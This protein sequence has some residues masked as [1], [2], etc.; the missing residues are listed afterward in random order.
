[1]P[2]E[3]LSEV[4]ELVRTK[5]SLAIENKNLIEES[6]RYSA[7]SNSKKTKLM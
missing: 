2:L 5:I 3:Y 7:L 4:K 1:M 6:M